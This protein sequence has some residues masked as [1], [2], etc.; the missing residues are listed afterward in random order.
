MRTVSISHANRLK[1]LLPCDM[2]AM[3]DIMKHHR[4]GAAWGFMNIRKVAE[5]AGVSVA[6]I[7]RVLNHPEQVLPETRD[8]VLAVM[9]EQNYT[10]NWFARGLNLG[11]TKTI[12]LLVPE[13]ESETQQRIISG[14]ETVA[15]NKGYAVFFCNT[16]G[17]ARIEEE[18]LNMCENRRV[19]G[20]ALVS[21]NIL[22]ERVL[23]TREAGIPCV[24][25]G[26]NRNS[27]CDTLCYIDFEEGAYR[28]TR[29]LL[30]FGYES[31]GLVRN[32]AERQMSAQM[33][34]G[35][36]SAL[37]E[38]Q[39]AVDSKL[40]TRESSVQ[41]GYLFAQQLIQQKMLPAALI[42]AGDGQ[43]L[44]ILKAAQDAGIP[45]PQQL[46][47]ASM[48]DSP[49]CGLVNPPVTALELPASKLGMAAGR[50]L[51]DSIENKDLELGV[52]QEMV[53]QPKLK[54]RRSCGN[55]KYIYELFD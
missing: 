4:K 22:L 25:V 10:P 50:L 48:T 35:F 17:D 12:A 39:K 21:S 32:N 18:S 27:G 15:R 14:I 47:L 24:H 38:S 34:A 1:D 9:K 30:S 45:V 7:S 52:P 26:K 43:A 16:H 33:E 20:I 53:L 54:I 51:F 55:E 36:A 28:L 3:R 41:S 42:S 40:Y 23:Q 5:V 8:H 2:L 29:H 37:R 13:I 49:I 19:D 46:A 6:T 44:G 11:T 31:I